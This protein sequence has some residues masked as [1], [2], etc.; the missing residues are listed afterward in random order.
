MSSSWPEW[1]VN[2]RPLNSVQTLSYQTMSLTRTYSQL[3]TAT[4]VSSRFV[5]GRISYRPLPSSV[6]TFIL[7]E[8][9][10]R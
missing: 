5:Q 9:L 7:I 6:A 1:D 8:S 10:L 2:P 3:C 4:P